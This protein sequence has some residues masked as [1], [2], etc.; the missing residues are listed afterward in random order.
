[1]D[2][3]KDSKMLN[4]KDSI[5]EQVKA[6]KEK[7]LKDAKKLS[8]NTTPGFASFVTGVSKE[9]ITGEANKKAEKEA[10]LRKRSRELFD[11]DN[12]YLAKIDKDRARKLYGFSDHEIREIFRFRE[13]QKQIRVK[14]NDPGFLSQAYHGIR[15]YLQPEKVEEEKILKKENAKE[16]RE[17]MRKKYGLQ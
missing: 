5:Q 6:I 16:K 11:I 10:L 4:Y 7:D 14:K 8:E 15:N 1:M 9:E 12:G 2:G 13:K 3:R 17:A